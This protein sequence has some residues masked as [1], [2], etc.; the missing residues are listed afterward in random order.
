MKRLLAFLAPLLMMAA[1]SYGGELS[2]VVDTR[3][4]DSPGNY[5]EITVKGG[6]NVVLDPAATA[7]S[8][9]GDT[10]L[11]NAVSVTLKDGSLSIDA[12]RKLLKKKGIK[13]VSVKE[14][15]VAPLSE[16]IDI[17]VPAPANL[18]EIDVAGAVNF[19]SVEPIKCGKLEIESAGANNIAFVCDIRELKVDAAGADNYRLEGPVMELDLDMAGACNFGAKDC[20]L[21]VNKAKVD[22]VGACSATIC[23]VG[24]V[25]GDAAGACSLAITGAGEA[26][27]KTR[28]ASSVTRF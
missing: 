25:K 24:T 20:Y 22:L 6:V 26:K 7:I 18:T 23:S 17:V 13:I 9:T 21:T 5:T 3:V 16:V 10:V 8:L 14:E 28:G 12:S 4:I 11:I 27:V 2:G 1:C 15:V 19:K